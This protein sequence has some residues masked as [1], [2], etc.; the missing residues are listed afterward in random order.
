MKTNHIIFQSLLSP[1]EMP[2]SLS[3]ECF[4]LNKSTSYQSLCLCLSILSQRKK[5]E[6][7]IHW[8]HVHFLK[9]QWRFS[10]DLFKRVCQFSVHFGTK[11]LFFIVLVLMGLNYLVIKKINHVEYLTRIIHY[12][13]LFVYKIYIFPF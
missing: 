13:L 1:S 9:S 6:P 12:D 4:S 7:P 10:H 3:V 2:H 11:I 8:E 5:Q